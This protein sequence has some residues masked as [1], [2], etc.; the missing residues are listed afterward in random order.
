MRIADDTLTLS[1]DALDNFSGYQ[2]ICLNS[3]AEEGMRQYNNGKTDVILTLRVLS[4]TKDFTTDT[5]K[6]TGL[7]EDDDL[8]KAVLNNN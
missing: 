6:V 1:Q 7:R 3:I 8:V 5:Y 2:D 4:D